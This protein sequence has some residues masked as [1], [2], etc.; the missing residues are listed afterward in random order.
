M[1][2]GTLLTAFHV[3]TWRISFFFF[4]FFPFCT[5]PNFG[6]GEEFLACPSH[7]GGRMAWL[8]NDAKLTAKPVY[9]GMTVD[10]RDVLL[11]TIV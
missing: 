6:G 2:S 3:K 7:A 10:M 4:F 9:H 1:T 5:F 11:A 8:F